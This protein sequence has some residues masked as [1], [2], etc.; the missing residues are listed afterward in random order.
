M[1]NNQSIVVKVNDRGPFHDNRLI[2]LSY[3][4]AHKLGF[5]EQGITKVKV[6]AITPPNPQQLASGHQFYLQAGAF[7]DINR[8]AALK[9]S[10]LEL[11][12]TPVHIK[13]PSADQ[14]SRFHRVRIGPFS[15]DKAAKKLQQTIREAQLADPLLIKH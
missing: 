6:E 14:S 3:A 5:A 4:A 2:D 10:L 7:R 1:A 9:Q 8:A 11:T 13:S 15:D 12:T